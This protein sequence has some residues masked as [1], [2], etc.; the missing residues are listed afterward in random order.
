VRILSVKNRKRNTLKCVRSAMQSITNTGLDERRPDM[1]PLEKIT[2]LSWHHS[3]PHILFIF[4]WGGEVV[5]GQGV[6]KGNFENKTIQI[7]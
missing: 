2:L 6:Q 5:L 4:F 1:R 7:C 3:L